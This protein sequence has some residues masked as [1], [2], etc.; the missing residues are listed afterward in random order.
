MEEVQVDARGS[1]K[2]GD[3]ENVEMQMCTT[4]ISQTETEKLKLKCIVIL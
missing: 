3:W 4:Q 2:E 1:T